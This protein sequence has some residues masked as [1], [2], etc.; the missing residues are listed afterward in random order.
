VRIV[1]LET[2]ERIGS[3]AAMCDD[4]LLTELRLDPTR[5]TA[6]S[7]APAIE[8]LLDKVCW[9]PQQIDLVGVTR[10]PGSFTGLRVG[11]TTAKVLAYCGR[12]DVLGINTLEAVAAGVPRGIDLLSVAI[13]A[14]REEVVAG[15][16]R[17]GEDGW[18]V[19]DLAPR[20]VGIDAWLE[21]LAAGTAI[22]GPVLRKLAGRVPDHLTILDQ[23]YWAPTASSVAA[24]AARLHAAGRRDD[25]WGLVPHYSRRSAAEEKRQRQ[26]PSD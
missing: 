12:A 7:L 8:E 21:M 25:L 26:Q 18:F 19:P 13:D 23:Q 6:Q 4:K 9:R 10:G 1:A 5:R 22:A 11:V 2:S 16:W 3:V 17:R 14:Q 24:L 15:D 20:L